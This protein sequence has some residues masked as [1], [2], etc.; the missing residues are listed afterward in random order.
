MKHMIPAINRAEVAARKAA[1]AE[2]TAAHGTGGTNAAALRARIDRLEK[3]VGVVPAETK[4][5]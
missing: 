2:A 1:K 5:K 4:P 3:I